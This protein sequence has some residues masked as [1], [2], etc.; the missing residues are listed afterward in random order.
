MTFLL[1]AATLI[2]SIIPAAVVGYGAAL[3]VRNFGPGKMDQSI[4]SFLA[5]FVVVYGLSV[6]GFIEWWVW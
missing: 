6:W 4:L 2:V 5:A 3:L 1:T